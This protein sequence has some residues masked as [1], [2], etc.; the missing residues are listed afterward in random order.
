MSRTECSILLDDG[1]SIDAQQ[2]D[3]E[4]VIPK[5]EGARVLVVA[6]QYRGQRA[7]L[8]QRNTEFSQAAIQLTEDFSICK[9][10]FDEIAEFVGEYGVDE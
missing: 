8:L 4:T 6:G 7:K 10:S 2:Q 1:R 9:V 3:L 5:K